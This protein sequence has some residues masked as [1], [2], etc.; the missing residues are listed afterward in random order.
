MNEFVEETKELEFCPEGLKNIRIS[1]KNY[2]VYLVKGSGENIEVRY[3]NNR[4]R[5]MQVTQNGNSLH[6]EE[7]MAVTLYEFFRLL[8]LTEDNKLE[9]AIPINCSE[10]NIS[11]E[12]GITEILINEI[13][14]SSIRAVSASGQIRI[15]DTGIGKSLTAN[16]SAG[17]IYCQISGSEADYNINCSTLRRDPTCFNTPWHWQNSDAEKK[18]SLHSD[19]YMPELIFV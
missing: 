19:V 1:C 6:F 10:L 12:T 15:C 3:H 5:E 16:S 18:I 11:I 7:K 17:T 13:Q 9:I 4:F 8:E 2:R 14:A